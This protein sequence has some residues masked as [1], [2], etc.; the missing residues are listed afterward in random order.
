MT[1]SLRADGRALLFPKRLYRVGEIQQ[2]PSIVPA[3]PG[4]YGWW[5]SSKLSGVP[6]ESTQ[7]RDGWRLLYV[8]IAPSRP[9]LAVR[10]RTLRDR[11][12]NHCFG[13]AATSTL[14]RSLA[15]LL[16]RT[17]KLQL[18][19][20]SSDKLC[21]KSTDEV[22]LSSWLDLNARVAWRRYDQPWLLECELIECGYPCLPL[23]IKGS[24][25]PFRLELKRLRTVAGRN[26]V[27]LANA[28]M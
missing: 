26:R 1:H 15:C 3:E 16:Q 18:R 9:T 17:L 25:H 6:I 22:R 24:A 19:R 27:R 10:P 14:R 4:I 8:G 13:P 23:N 21:M 12:K 28:H 2:C 11:I 5:F 7:L 20:N